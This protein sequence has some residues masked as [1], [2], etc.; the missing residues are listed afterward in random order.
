MLVFAKSIYD[1]RGMPTTGSSAEWAGLFPD[2]VSRDALEVAGMRAA[3]AVV[4]GKTAADD[5]AYRGNGTSSL[6]ARS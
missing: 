3:G 4:L 5:F 6:R 1:M 2:A